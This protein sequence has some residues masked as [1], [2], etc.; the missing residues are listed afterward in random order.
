MWIDRSTSA[1]IDHLVSY[2]E[3]QWQ[4]HVPRPRQ[5]PPWLYS[6]VERDNY[7]A[8]YQKNGDGLQ[9]VHVEET[10]HKRWADK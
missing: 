2:L 3:I 9:N 10:G 7:F 6:Q 5:I 1:Q 8:N 4:G